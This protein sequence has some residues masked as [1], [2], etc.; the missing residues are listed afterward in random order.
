LTRDHNRLPRK[1]SLRPEDTSSPALASEA[2]ADRDAHWISG[3]FGFELT[4]TARGDSCAHGSYWG[5]RR[6]DK[7]RR[8]RAAVSFIGLLGGSL[9]MRQIALLAD[10]QRLSHS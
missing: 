4:A 3:D 2:V 6:A 1:P 7:L 8:R 9:H 5:D 10:A